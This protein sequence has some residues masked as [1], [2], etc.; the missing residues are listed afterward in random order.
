MQ[1]IERVLDL[2]SELKG[3]WRAGAGQF[4]FSTGVLTLEFSSYN[5]LWKSAKLDP[6]SVEMFIFS[7]N[8]RKLPIGWGFRIQT[9][10]RLLMVDPVC[11]TH[12]LYQFVQYTA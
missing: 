6:N 9:S 3:A 8:S 7:N 4:N 11:N 2:S 1:D 12:V 5:W 10:L